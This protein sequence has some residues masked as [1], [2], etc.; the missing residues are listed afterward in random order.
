[1]RQFKLCLLLLFLAILTSSACAL[2][3][4]KRGRARALIG[5]RHRC[6]RMGLPRSFSS[7]LLGYVRSAKLVPGMFRRVK[8]CYQRSTFLARVK[9]AIRVCH[10]KRLSQVVR[11]NR[12]KEKL[13]K[14]LGGGQGNFFA[15]FSTSSCT[16]ESGCHYCCL[17]RSIAGITECTSC[18]HNLKCS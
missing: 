8:G 5:M 1:M 7:C 18:P 6:K 12:K 17:L 2:C 15:G 10:S 3:I 11:R 13:A 4:S 16:C 14:Q 9:R